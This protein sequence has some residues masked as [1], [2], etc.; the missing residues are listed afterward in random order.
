MKFAVCVS[1][2]MLAVSLVTLLTLGAA[3]RASPAWGTLEGSAGEAWVGVL[4]F[5]ALY[6]L[7]FSAAALLCLGATSLVQRRNLAD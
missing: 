6:T 2:V 3:A 7:I 1:T 5:G 4:G